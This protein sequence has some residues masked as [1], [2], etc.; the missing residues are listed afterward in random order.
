[1]QGQSP[2]AASK[3]GADKLA[4]SFY[5]SYGLPIVTVRPFNAY[6]PRQ[7]ARAVIPTIITQ[8]LVRDQIHLGDLTP[9]RDFTYVEDTARAFIK[10]A[11]ADGV[12]GE[13]INV[14]SGQEI[15]I[16]DLVQEILNLVGRTVQVVTQAR[17]LRPAQSEVR[18]L[19][20]DNR[21]AGELLKWSPSVP[22]SEG[23]SRT[24][25]WI[26]VHLDRYRPGEYQ[27]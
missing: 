11:Q 16:G 26:S 4:E 9:R 20:A 15:S 5:C 17:R 2:Y 13:T 24:I 27:V 21:K 22:L 25:A 14:G 6:G 18:R 1:L 3:I 10:A 7:S 19:L 23:L 8:A 12:E